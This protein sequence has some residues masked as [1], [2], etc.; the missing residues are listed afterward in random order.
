MKRKV[1]ISA[2][3]AVAL[4]AV[5]SLGLSSARADQVVPVACK[6]PVHVK[7]NV[8]ESGCYNNPGPTITL[9]GA[10]T[11]GGLGANLIFENNLKGT[12]SALVETW[13][14]NIA[15]V[16]L[17]SAIIIPKQP[18]LGGV[19]GNPHIYFQ[20]LDGK[21]NA[22]TQELYLGRCVQGLSLEG[23]FLNDVIGSTTIH[24]DGCNNNPGPVITMGGQIVLSG[25]KARIIFRN[26][27]KG[28]H[29]T[30]RFSDV[31]LIIE[32]T[33]VTIPKSP[34]Q[35]GAGGNPLILLQFLQCDETPI[36]DLFLLGRC[37]KL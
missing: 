7:C 18:V 30:Q 22:L 29:T 24:T 34:H 31:D 21:S 6:M 16:P 19:G 1:V 10:I 37:N 33:R 25:L 2:C 13:A 4:L 27:V 32:G 26:N 11:L 5:G 36:G 14:T 8:N 20:F 28:T 23:D 15:L 17:G 12:H 35:G 3:G 9:D